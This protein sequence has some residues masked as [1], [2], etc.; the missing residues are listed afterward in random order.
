LEYEKISTPNLLLLI[1]NSIS[2]S[3]KKQIT[4]QKT[5]T[6]QSSASEKAQT[7]SVFLPLKIKEAIT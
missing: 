2:Y 6:R 7:A 4:L 5:V 1:I 3:D